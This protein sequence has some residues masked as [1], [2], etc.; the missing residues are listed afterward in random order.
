MSP[1]EEEEEIKGKSVVSGGAETPSSPVM[2]GVLTGPLTLPAV[3]GDG[4]GERIEVKVL[5][6]EL[7]RLAL[8]RENSREEE[9]GVLGSGPKDI[10]EGSRAEKE[11][12]KRDRGEEKPIVLKGGFEKGAMDVDGCADTGFSDLELRDGGI[13]RRDSAGSGGSGSR[14]MSGTPG[15]VEVVDGILLKKPRMNLGA[16]LGQM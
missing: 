8:E 7:E 15:E 12:L 1:F 13:M 6:E 2:E 10:F 5:T 3:P 4:V 14:R 11:K 9:D 16:P